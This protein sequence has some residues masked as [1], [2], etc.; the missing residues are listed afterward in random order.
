MKAGDA[1]RG[2]KLRLESWPLGRLLPSP[3]NARTHS[4]AQ[5]AEIA[6]SIRAFGFSNPILAG[7]EGDIIAGHGRL[8]AAQQL[9][10]A[11][12]PVVVLSGL[13]EYERRQLLLADNRIAMNAG[14]N[15][16]MLSL[17]LKELS[18]LGADLQRLGFTAQELA[19]ALSPASSGGLTDENAV[20]ETPKKAVTL[21]GDI[22]CA[23]PHRIACG[24]STDPNVVSALLAGTTPNLMVTDPPYGVNYEP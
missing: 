23:G 13:T 14:W 8:A 7:D 12:V 6:G 18:L 24:D 5:V 9:G 1:Q 16:Q 21:P 20:P 10:L 15:L 3:R 19:R 4:R 22:W 17:E 2:T 11:E